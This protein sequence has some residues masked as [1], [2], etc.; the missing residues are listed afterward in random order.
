MGGQLS[1]CTTSPRKGSDVVLENTCGQHFTYRVRGEHVEFLGT[2]DLHDIH[3]NEMEESTSHDDFLETYNG[4]SMFNAYTNKK[5]NAT[6]DFADKQRNSRAVQTAACTGTL[7][8]STLGTSELE[9]VYATNTPLIYAGVVAL[10]VPLSRFAVRTD[11]STTLVRASSIA[12]AP[13]VTDDNR[14]SWESYAANSDILVQ[15]NDTLAATASSI[16]HPKQ[17]LLHDATRSID[18]GIS[19]FENDTVV[20]DKGPGPYFQVWQVSPFAENV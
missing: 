9:A 2:G 11:G 8:V 20:D 1:E 6:G 16:A 13:L 18:D 17:Q 14:D 12:L 3:Y 19:R 4:A 10:N 15:L 7:C 5:S